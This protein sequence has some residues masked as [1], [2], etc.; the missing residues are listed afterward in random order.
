MWVQDYWYCVFIN[1]TFEIK[2]SFDHFSHL[3][4]SD[5]YV[6]QGALMLPKTFVSDFG[7][8]LGDYATFIH[9]YNNQFE[10]MVERM[11]GSMFL[12]TGFNVICNFYDVRLGGTI[13]MCLPVLDNLGLMWLID[14]DVLWILLFL[15][16]LW[17]LKGFGYYVQYCTC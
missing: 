1:A 13:V 17:N 8:S 2:S 16:L 6:F 5:I 3:L 7:K 10:V 15:F 14:Q 9:P 12:T 11:C 4:I